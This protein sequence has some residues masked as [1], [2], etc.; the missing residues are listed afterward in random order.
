[1]IDP[2]HVVT[3]AHC[4]QDEKPIVS[5]C[6]G[7][8]LIMKIR[9]FFEILSKAFVMGDDV[10]VTVKGSETRQRRKVAHF[11]PHPEFSRETFQ[12]DIAVIRVRIYQRMYSLRVPNFGI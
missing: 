12:N 7:Y 10:M 4:F 9:S 5:R 1:M 6:F 11:V 8:L 3:A 2:L